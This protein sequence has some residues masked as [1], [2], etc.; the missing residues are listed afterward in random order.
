MRLS[1]NEQE[2]FDLFLAKE[3][4]TLD[5]ILSEFPAKRSSMVVRLKYLSAKI[6]EEGWFIRRISSIGRGAKAQ[7]KLERTSKRK[8]KNGS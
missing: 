3:T 4:L 6:S 7:Y 5:E 1:P 2:I 8:P